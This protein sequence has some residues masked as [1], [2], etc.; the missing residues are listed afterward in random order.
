[1]DFQILHFPD[2]EYNDW[3]TGDD[4]PSAAVVTEAVNEDSDEG[5]FWL[6]SNEAP[7]LDSFEFSL[8]S[9]LTFSSF[10]QQASDDF[11]PIGGLF[12]L[13]FTC[14]LKDSSKFLPSS[15]KERLPEHFIGI[16]LLQYRGHR[17]LQASV[18][19]HSILPLR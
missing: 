10:M 16:V 8:S 15:Y 4:M 2:A 17:D 14:G 18:R 11:Q 12:P 9:C 5:T 1:M 19:Y 6:G 3:L 7:A 13:T